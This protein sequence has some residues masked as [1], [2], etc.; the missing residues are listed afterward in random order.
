MLTKL[1]HPIHCLPLVFQ[2][3]PHFVFEWQAGGLYVRLG[4]RDWFW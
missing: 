3:G 2:F 4:K 1:L